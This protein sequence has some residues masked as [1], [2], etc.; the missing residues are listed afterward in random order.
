M[1]DAVN[2]NTLFDDNR[3]KILQFSNICDGTGESDVKKVDISADSGGPDGSVPSKYSIQEVQ[4][5]IQ[6]FTSVLI[7]FDATT[8][9]TALVLSGNGYKD[10]TSVGGLHDP[11]STGA[12]GDIFLTTAGNAAGDAY[13]IV[14]HLKKHA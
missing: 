8:D 7:E 14:L 3:R 2:T 10:F 9:D 13:D 6:G 12:T 1:A 5:D 4:Y 11:Q